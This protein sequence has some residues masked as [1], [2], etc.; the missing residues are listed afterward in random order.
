M[1]HSPFSSVFSFYLFTFSSCF[2]PS[3]AHYMQQFMYPSPP[4]R[5]ES[6]SSSGIPGA[7]LLY[8]GT[9]LRCSAKNSS[10]V[11]GTMLLSTYWAM[12]K[13]GSPKG[14]Y[15][16]H[17]CATGQMTRKVSE[18]RFCKAVRGF[19]NTSLHCC[20]NSAVS[21]I[22]AL[23]YLRF[24]GQQ[25]IQPAQRLTRAVGMTR[26]ISDFRHQINNFLPP[27]AHCC[28]YERAGSILEESMWGWE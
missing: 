5:M 15:Q 19:W 17:F 23:P 3:S 25:W 21:A 27:P 7:C 18:E 16:E 14:E 28:G 6:T 12:E 11:P 13:D 22:F 26:S 2:C 4:E 24:L 1:P 9:Q 20:V 8:T 10:W